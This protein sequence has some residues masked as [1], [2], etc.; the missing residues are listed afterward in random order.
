MALKTNKTNMQNEKQVYD[1]LLGI[2][3]YL[4]S[5]EQRHERLQVYNVKFYDE[6][7]PIVVKSWNNTT[8]EIMAMAS[9]I[10]FRQSYGVEYVQ[11]VE[12]KVKHPSRLSS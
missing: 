7:I 12:T 10:L 9:R 4:S 5:D 6:P 11:N 1:T 3:G 8:A 2:G